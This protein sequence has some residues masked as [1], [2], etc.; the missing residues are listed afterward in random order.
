MDH[1]YTD[2]INTC[3]NTA[4]NV[5]ATNVTTTSAV[6]TWTDSSTVANWQVA[7]YPLTNC[8]LHLQQATNSYTV[9]GL[10]PN[11]YYIVE[12]KPSCTAG[13]VSSSREFIF[14]TST[15]YCAGISVSDTEDQL[16]IT[17]IWK[18]L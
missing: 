17:R 9:S 7:V 18:P 5:Q 12:V 3:I 13:L 4:L 11:S 1:V 10:I 15:T 16:L 6:I 8:K 14:A 2:C